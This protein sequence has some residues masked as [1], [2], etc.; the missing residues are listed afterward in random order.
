MDT[1]CNHTTD[2]S[3]S[4]INIIRSGVDDSYLTVMKFKPFHLFR[5]FYYITLCLCRLFLSSLLSTHSYLRFSL[6]SQQCCN[7]IFVFME[8]LWSRKM[9]EKNTSVLNQQRFSMNTILLLLLFL[10]TS[11]FFFSQLHSSFSG[12]RRVLS[13]VVILFLSNLVQI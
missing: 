12:F 13:R 2:T 11:L 4:I 7:T 5:V 8:M 10:W 6:N 3:K 9:E 1:S